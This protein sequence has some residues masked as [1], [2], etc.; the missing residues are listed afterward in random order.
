MGKKYVSPESLSTGIWTR[1]LLYF[2]RDGITRINSSPKDLELRPILGKKC[3]P[4]KCRKEPNGC[5]LIDQGD[6]QIIV[7]K[8][9]VNV[10]AAYFEAID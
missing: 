4:I 9:L 10:E 8:T 1:I 2:A 5:F 7:K 6:G 3:Q